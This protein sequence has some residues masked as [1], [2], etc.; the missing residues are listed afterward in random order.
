MSY[1][2]AEQNV[3]RQLA[4]KRLRRL[5]RQHPAADGAGHGERRQRPARRNFVAAMIA[6]EPRCRLRAGR[7]RRHQRADAAGSVHAPARSRRRRYGSCADR[8]RRSSPPSRSW[9]RARC[10]LP[11]ARRARPPPQQN[12]V[13]SKLRGDVR[14]YEGPCDPKLFQASM[15]SALDQIVKVGRDLRLRLDLPHDGPPQLFLVAH[16]SFGLRR[17]HV[18]SIGA[19]LGEPLDHVW[20]RH[21]LRRSALIFWTMLS[22]VPAGAINISQPLDTTPGTVSS[23]VGRSG[24]FGSALCRRD[25]KH[26]HAAVLDARRRARQTLKHDRDTARDHIIE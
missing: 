15:F 26:P 12:G 20:L 5:A 22:G 8:R 4:A 13:R 1:R 23:M 21:D 25:A 3:E 19:E 2:R 24:I 11:P 18:A 14:R 16:E 9:P 6:I 17:R 7:T 10:R